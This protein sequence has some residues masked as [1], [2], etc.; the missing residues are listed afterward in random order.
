LKTDTGLTWTR[1]RQYLNYNPD[2]GQFTN[3]ATGKPTGCAAGKYGRTQ[4]W[5]DGKGRYANR[6]AWYY[7]H[8]EWPNGQVD[9]INGDHTDNR[10]SNLRVLDNKANKQ[11]TRRPYSTNRTGILGVS[12]NERSKMYRARITADGRTVN[13]G[14]YADKMDAQLA[15]LTAK[16]RMHP[17]WVA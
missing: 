12:Y 4:I 11:N 8:G 17:A 6:L 15:Y 7:I 2:T 16:E 10:I 3:A 9:H 13:L 1:L 5:I 14:T